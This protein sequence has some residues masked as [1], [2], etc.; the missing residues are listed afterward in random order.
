MASETIRSRLSDGCS[1]WG[2]GRAHTEGM[3]CFSAGIQSSSLLNAHR[4]VRRSQDAYSD[5]TCQVPMDPR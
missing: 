4:S 5:L 3:G 1:R 2:R